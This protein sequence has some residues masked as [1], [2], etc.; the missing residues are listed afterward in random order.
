MT[1]ITWGQCQTFE[2]SEA[3]WFAADVYKEM[4][5]NGLKACLQSANVRAFDNGRLTLR[6]FARSTTFSN[7]LRVNSQPDLSIS[8]KSTSRSLFELPPSPPTPLPLPL[9][10][11]LPPS[12]PPAAALRSFP[13]FFCCY[14]CCSQIA[15]L[16]DKIYPRRLPFRL[17]LPFEY[18]YS[19]AFQRRSSRDIEMFLL[20]YRDTFPFKILLH[21][22]SQ[23][24]N[25][26]ASSRI[27]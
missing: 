14:C 6:F 20:K 13:D 15:F 4:A 27:H 12:S 1:I 2:A 8:N 7:R 26:N 5:F 18:L 3:H 21:D 22:I 16:L 25:R 23:Y 17:S 10:P 11:P 24:G 9:P 19:S